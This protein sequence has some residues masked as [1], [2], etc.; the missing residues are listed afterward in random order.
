MAYIK[1]M[2]FMWSYVMIMIISNNLTFITYIW[3]LYLLKLCKKA[4]KSMLQALTC[5]SIWKKNMLNALCDPGYTNLFVFI[6]GKQQI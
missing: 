2:S 5:L 6:Y 4:Q 3:T 1:L